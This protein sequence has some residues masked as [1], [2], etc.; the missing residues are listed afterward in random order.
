MPCLG[1]GGGGGV[2]DSIRTVVWIPKC[3]IYIPAV[4]LPRTKLRARFRPMQLNQHAVMV[5][6]EFPISLNQTTRAIKSIDVD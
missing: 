2:P 1:G 4:S 5:S 6:I 3:K